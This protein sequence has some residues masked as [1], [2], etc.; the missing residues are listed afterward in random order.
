MA[1]PKPKQGSSPRLSQPRLATNDYLIH[2]E[3]KD[4][5]SVHTMKII[6]ICEN[7][8]IIAVPIYSRNWAM[9]AVIWDNHQ[10]NKALL[11]T[12]GRKVRRA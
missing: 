6:G 5:N 12:F 2:T 1:I 8:R 11:K 3:L 4:P 10:I 7:G 9:E